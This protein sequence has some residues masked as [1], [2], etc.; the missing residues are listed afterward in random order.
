M[1]YLILNLFNFYLNLFH[2]KIKEFGIEFRMGDGILQNNVIK[3]N[4]TFGII[5]WTHDQKKRK[6]FEEFLKTNKVIDNLLGDC[7]AKV[8]PNVETNYDDPNNLTFDYF[9]DSAL[10]DRVC[11]FA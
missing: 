8:I 2:Q 3:N 6:K 10:E 7:S 11:T 5:G 4:K 9:I 1:F